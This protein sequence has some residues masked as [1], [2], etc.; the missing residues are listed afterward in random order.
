MRVLLLA[1]RYLGI[2][3]GAL[4]V[5]WCL[6]GVVMVFVPFPRLPEERRLQGL[7]PIAWEGCCRFESGPLHDDLGAGFAIEML[8]QR[9]VLRARAR[10]G[11]PAL[12]DLLTGAAIAHVSPREAAAVAQ[13]FA[14]RSREAGRPADPRA[15]PRLL[16]LVESDQWT[17]GGVSAAERPVYRFALDDRAG[18]EVYVS[19]RSGRAVQA[20]TACQRFWSWL[21]S[22]PHWLY[23]AR[24]RAHVA[25]W[26]AVVVYASLAG[27]FL[28]AMGIVI[29][30]RQLRRRPGRRWSP[31]RGFAWW[32]HVAGLFF[33]IFTLTWVA[34][35]LLSMNPWGL[36]DSDD[37]QLERARLAGALSQS[38]RVQA[39][40]E[41]VKAQQRLSS[42]VSVAFAPLGGRPYFVV[43]AADGQR[44]RLDATGRPA[45]LDALDLSRIAAELDP[46]A[47]PTAPEELREGDAYFFSGRHEP[48]RLPV[49][50]VVAGGADGARY[51]LDPV[52]GNIEAKVDRNGRRYRW[53]H[54]GLH[55]LDFTSSLRSGPLGYV[56]LLSLMA[57]VLVVCM[58]GAYL[59]WRR[60]LRWSR[61]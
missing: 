11:S 29:G 26:T 55:R 25:L 10:D 24:L 52:S 13:A 22:I 59:G 23:F 51:Y 54:G 17:V 46:R 7:S 38:S 1:H 32:H 19:S 31:Y 48:P 35:G 14:S 6:S 43:A 12:F 9:P 33:G 21:G 44:R 5:S 45:T 37:A 58:T 36:L 47:G 16:A 42:A 30:L 8:A 20:T 28:T 41:A 57:G 15:A 53:L 39:G 27:C 4:M 61:G 3:V 40:I 34:S 50:R 60:L 2:A 56:L 49:F 18:T